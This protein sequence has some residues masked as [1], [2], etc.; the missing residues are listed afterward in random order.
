MQRRMQ[1]LQ[2]LPLV[3]SALALA[4][5]IA[6]TPVSD[7]ALHVMHMALFAAP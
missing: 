7:G 4:V 6:G 5:A 1:F 2:W 3:L